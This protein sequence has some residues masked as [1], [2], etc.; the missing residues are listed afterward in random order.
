MTR[1]FDDLL[2]PA[3]YADDAQADIVAAASAPR[4][5]VLD[6]KT[7]Q[8][9][10]AGA[11]RE[12]KWLLDFRQRAERS[13]YVFAKGVLGLTRLTP[14]L[15][16]PGCDWLMTTPPYRKL[17]LWPRDHLK[18][19]IVSRALSLHALIQP[20][21]KSPYL[22]TKDGQPFA[23]QDARILLA[24]ETAANAEKQLGWIEL[25]CEGN[26]RL[27][28]LWPHLMW[29]SPRKQAKA[30]NA[31]AMVLPRTV[32]F[33]EASIETIGVGG[34]V[35]G[36]HYD[37]M[38]KDDLATFDAANSAVIMQQAI[39]WHEASRALLDD[40][41]TG[42]EFTVGTRW[43]VFDLYDHIIRDDPSVAVLVR[44]AIEDGQPIFPEMFSLATLDEYKKRLGVL[45]PL[46]YMNTAIDAAIS[47]FAI[48]AVREFVIENGQLTFTEDERD[49]ELSQR[50]NQPAPPSVIPRGVRLTS[51]TYDLLDA[52]GQYVRLRRTLNA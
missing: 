30:W 20:R 28:A 22:P 13:L 50:L 2:D 8:P 10:Q 26:A 51:A 37:I 39:D 43:A 46:L 4:E 18:T 11:D 21:G 25:Q 7:G 17:L 19:S 44:A 31:T 35:T 24:G 45:F 49:L 3:A 14:T 52:R 15:H 40:P 16:K 41:E 5:L 36:R 9:R 33:P 42:V 1:T 12:G 32:D 47:D 23:G 27:R 29:D 6:A 48:E 34:A 38:I